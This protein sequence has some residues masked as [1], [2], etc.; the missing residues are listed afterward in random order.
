MFDKMVGSLF[1]KGCR[2]RDRK[3]QAS[4][5][6]VSQLMRLFSGVIGAIDQAREDGGDVLDRIETQVGGWKLVAAKPKRSGPDASFREL[7]AS[8]S[9][10]PWCSCS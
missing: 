3:Y 6:E 2:G 5:R 8:V 10:R 9:D 7:T 1:A 4:S